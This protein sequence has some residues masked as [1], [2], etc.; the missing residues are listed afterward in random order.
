MDLNL[1]VIFITGFGIIVII[2]L[3]TLVYVIRQRTHIIHLQSNIQLLQ[4]G[5][6]T[7]RVQLLQI[8]QVITAQWHDLSDDLMQKLNVAQQQQQQLAHQLEKRML[9]VTSENRIIQQRTLTELNEQIQRRLQQHSELFDKRQMESLKLLQDSMLSNMQDIRSQVTQ[10]LTRHTEQLAKRVDKLNVDNNLRLK[11]ISGQVEKRLS[12]GFE[13]TTAVFADVLKRLALIDVAQKK[14]T[15]LSSNVVSLQ[16]VLADKRSRGAFGEVQLSALIRNMMPESHVKFQHTLSNNKRADCILLLPQP[17]G[18]IVIDAKFPLESYQRMQLQQKQKPVPAIDKDVKIRRSATQQFRIDIRKHI[19][20]IAE[21]YIIPGETADGAMMFIPAE[22][23]FACIHSDYPEL[24]Q[25][26]QQRKVW[27]TSPTTMMAI[28]TTARA[29]LKDADTR[30][31]VHII[32]EHLGSLA[33]DFD[34]FQ[35]RMDSLARHIDQAHDDVQ[36]VNTSAR[37]ISHRFQKI[38]RVELQ[39]E[40][41]PTESQ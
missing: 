20:D 16:E 14:I 32:Q 33:K 36:N 2:G 1:P 41:T 5:D 17:T 27:L 11:E 37:K 29:V 7:A 31:Q 4:R 24:V 3:M 9:A 22:A 8:S 38:E 40:T 21:K 23:I 28:I 13:K 12:D 15:E 34:R 26:A 6:E 25:E 30:R 35:K 10:T 39:Q 18:N 19:H